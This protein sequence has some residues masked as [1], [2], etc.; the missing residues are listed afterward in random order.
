MRTLRIMFAAFCVLACWVG[1]ASAAPDG[2]VEVR[3]YALIVGANDGGKE[4]VMLRY[5]VTDAQAMSRVLEQLGGIPKR[6]QSLVMN[7]SVAEVE[8]ALKDLGARIARERAKVKRAE[9][10]VYY[11]GHSDEQGLLLKGERMPYAA[12]R[13]GLDGLNA[14]VRVVVLDSCSSG[15]MTREKGGA[16]VAS[17]LE[18]SSVQ[19]KGQATLTSSAADEVAQES[20]TLGGSFFTHALI[21]GLRGAADVTGDRRVTLNLSLI[22][23]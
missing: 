11:S 3:R 17:F 16:R 2:G 5:A 21:S 12:L 6:E 20:D 4:R 8:G 10:L 22:H 1:A 13:A 15:A 23:I 19:V 14:Q 7:P 9:V 18:D